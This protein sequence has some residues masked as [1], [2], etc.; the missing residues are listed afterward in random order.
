MSDS[1]YRNSRILVRTERPVSCRSRPDAAPS[2]P[3]RAKRWW[4]T[5]LTG[6]GTDRGAELWQHALF[7]APDAAGTGLHPAARQC[8][9][10]RETH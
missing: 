4:R 6:P 5:H 9:D 3:A 8:L 2:L 10:W 7:F 1:T